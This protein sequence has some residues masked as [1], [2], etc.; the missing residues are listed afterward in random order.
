MLSWASI[1][2]ADPTRTAARSSAT[3]TRII[4]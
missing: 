1:S 4:D 3:S 2:A